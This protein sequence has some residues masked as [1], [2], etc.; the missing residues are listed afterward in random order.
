[1]LH[2]HFS[3][4]RGVEGFAVTPPLI[5]IYIFLYTVCICGCALGMFVCDLGEGIFNFGGEV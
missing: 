3:G 1:M 5:Y 2:T 4:E